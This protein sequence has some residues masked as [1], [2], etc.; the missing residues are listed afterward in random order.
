[1]SQSTFFS[2]NAGAIG[3]TGAVGVTGATGSA[4]YTT[5]LSWTSGD[6]A[7]PQEMDGFGSVMNFNEISLNGSATAFFTALNSMWNWQPTYLNVSDT[8]GQYATIG[9][10]GVSYLSGVWTITGGLVVINGISPFI[11]TVYANFYVQTSY[12]GP[13]GETGFTGP[14]GHTGFTGP[15]GETGFTGPTGPTGETGPT[16]P[17]GFTG[18]TG[19]TGYTGYTGETGHTGAASTVT[20]PTGAAGQNGISSGFV[21]TLDTTTGSFTNSNS[22]TGSALMGTLIDVPNITN[23]QII[24]FQRNAAI[25]IIYNVATFVSLPNSLPSPVILGGY[26][27]LNMYIKGISHYNKMYFFFNAYYVD[28]DGVSNETVIANGDVE[29]AISVLGGQNLLTYS[30]PIPTLTLSDNTKRLKIYF[31][32]VCK[33]NTQNVHIEIEFRHNTQSHLHTTLLANSGTGPTG[34]VGPTGPTGMTGPTGFTGMTGPTGFTG[35]TGIM[36]STYTLSSETGGISDFSNVVTIL[37]EPTPAASSTTLSWYTKAGTGSNNNTKFVALSTDSS[38]IY[39]VG[40]YKTNSITDAF[41]VYSAAGVSDTTNVTT[42]F[43]NNS[44]DYPSVIIKYDGNGLAQWVSNINSNL[45]GSMKQNEVNYIA[46]DISN[47]YVIGAFQSNVYVRPAN[48]LS[49]IGGTSFEIKGFDENGSYTPY[50]IKYL[51]TDGSIPWY[52]KYNTNNSLSI[53]SDNAKIISSIDIDNQTNIISI[54]SFVGSTISPYNASGTGTPTASTI[55]YNNSNLGNF[56]YEGHLTKYSSGSGSVL[57]GCCSNSQNINS[58]Y[59]TSVKCD[60]GGNIFALGYTKCSII[61]Y[62]GTG[63]GN[64]N[65]PYTLTVSSSNTGNNN[66]FIVKFNSSGTVQWINK[67]ESNSSNKYPTDITVDNSNN[68]YVSGNFGGTNSTITLF[69]ANGTNT[70]TS[71]AL[72][73]TTPTSSGDVYLIKYNGDN[74]GVEWF[75]KLTTS[76]NSSSI[77]LNT[78]LYGRSLSVDSNNYLYVTG[79]FTNNIVVYN[80]NGVNNVSGTSYTM[81]GESISQKTFI[82]KYSPTGIVATFNKINLNQTASSEV[83]P[84]AITNINSNLFVCGYSSG[85]L[86]MYNSSGTTDPTSATLNITPGDNKYNTFLNKYS[87]IDPITT[88]TLGT[89]TSN[90][91]SKIIVNNS[92]STTYTINTTGGENIY[93]NGSGSTSASLSAK[94]T[95]NLLRINPNWFSL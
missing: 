58:T 55:T 18:P 72:A 33:A 90:G 74:G 52:T 5:I 48:G 37:G 45:S 40:N 62:N 42:T 24:T 88:L 82:V 95:L 4:G 85:N 61:L 83:V 79:T 59:Y 10:S 67:I 16:G 11:G 50:I 86:S 1:M 30:I 12:T 80:A 57:W 87:T 66:P 64:G 69:N 19:Y 84:T 39:T 53:I 77:I 51:N 6:S 7:N 89:T 49:N 9:I 54:G 94:Q 41:N 28:S 91:T 81:T 34:P 25:N 21:F 29:S 15:T 56:G 68:V 71:V 27:D 35:P 8:T 38:N 70:P 73:V 92:A 44:Q 60:S 20:G 65:T 75:N 78:G 47:T 36:G 93:T 3:P 17:T 14:T 63:T 13:T 26:W 76:N 2:I 31:N 43:Y 32:L 22:P 23:Q 46:S